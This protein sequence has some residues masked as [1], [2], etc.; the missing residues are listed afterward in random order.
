MLSTAHG[1]DVSRLLAQARRHGTRLQ[2]LLLS[3]TYF[4]QAP[5]PRCQSESPVQN[6]SSRQRWHVETFFNLLQ[7]DGFNPLVIQYEKFLVGG[8]F[9]RP[10][11]LFEKLLKSTGSRQEAYQQLSRTI[12]HAKKVQDATHGEGFWVDHWTYNLDLLESFAAI[13]PD[14]L[15]ALLVDRRDFTYFDNDH[16]VQPRDKKYVLR[17]DGVVR[18][19]HAV[20]RDAEK[21]KLLH[22]RKEEPHKVRTKNGS[23]SIYESS[24]LAKMLNIIVDESGVAGSLSVS[25]WKWKPKSRAGATR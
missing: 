16:V 3:P 9:I 4:S 20:V 24:L 5:L 25:A 17:S 10:G 13:Y 12:A 23:G 2:F 1:A 8:K 14:Q 19:M 18:Q 22:R 7:F 15:K 6:I 11:D 21:S